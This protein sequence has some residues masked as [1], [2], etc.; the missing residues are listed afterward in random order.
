MA[1]LKVEI[2]DELKELESASGI[3][4]QL[5]VEKRLK[6]EFEELARLKRIVSKSKLTEEQ[7]KELA[8]DVNLS[9]AK[10]YKGL[11]KGK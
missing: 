9:L 2:P 7:A 11:L 4:W 6:E 3:N 10:K 8:D 5:A 1:E